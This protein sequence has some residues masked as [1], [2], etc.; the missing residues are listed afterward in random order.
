MVFDIDETSL[1]N[2]QELLQAD[3]AYNK[4]AFDAWSE[5]GQAPAG[6]AS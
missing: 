1:S 2:W 6:D 3:F 5:T 4:A